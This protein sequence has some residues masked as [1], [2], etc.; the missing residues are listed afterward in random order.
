MIATSEPFPL[1]ISPEGY[2]PPFAY[3]WVGEGTLTFSK[4]K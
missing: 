3:T 4:G 2:T 1:E